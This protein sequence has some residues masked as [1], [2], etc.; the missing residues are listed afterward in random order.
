MIALHKQ[1]ATLL[2]LSCCHP[3]LLLLLKLPLFYHSPPSPS[4]SL[5]PSPCLF[6][7][8]WPCAK[9]GVTNTPFLPVI[10]GGYIC[11]LVFSGLFERG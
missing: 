8:I 10:K 4:S 5:S 1:N 2:S 3:L 9:P 11:V 7:D 6:K